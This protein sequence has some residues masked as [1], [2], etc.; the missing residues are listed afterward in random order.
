MSDQIVINDNTAGDSIFVNQQTP[1]QTITVNTGGGVISVN[2]QN[3]IVNLTKFD[4]GLGL[5]DNTSDLDKPISNATLSALLLK[6][7]LSAFNILNNFV[8]SKYGSWDSVYSVVNFNSGGWAGGGGGSSI[9]PVVSGIWQ[10]SASTVSSL[11]TNWNLGYQAVSTTNALALS[12][13][14]WNTAY[15]L[16]SGGIVVSFSL[17]Q[18][19]NW[20]STY[21]TVSSLSAN[22]NSVY[23]TFNTNSGSLTI[24]SSNSA[25]W[26]LAY[27]SI[28]TTNALNL[29]SI[30][31]NTG[32]NL[33][34][35][36]SAINWNYQGT[37]LKGLSANWQTAYQSVSTT[38]TLNLS[39]VYWNTA[40]ASTSA[41][42]LAGYDNEIH[43]SQID[44]ND[45]TGNGDLLNPVASITKALT[46]VGGSRKTVIIHPGG[47][48]E[49]PSITYPYTVLTGPGLVGGNIVIYGT[50]STSTGCTIQ[51]LKMT[52]LTSTT[53]TGAG[54]VNILNCDI[55]NLTQSGTADYTLI[56]FCDITSTNITGS[57]GLI[58]I[59]GGNPN[60]ITINN[61]GAR[62]IAKNVVTVAPVLSAGNATFVD[63]IV[64]AANATSNA[65]TTAPGTIVTLANSQIIVPTFN[66]VARVSL[67]GFYSIFNC[68]YDKPNSTLVALSL[69]GGST[70]SIDYFQYI[71]ADRLILASSGQI[72]FPDGSIQ[73]TAFLNN[74][75]SY[76]T[77]T[78]LQST[79]ALLTPL[80]LTNTLTSQLVTNTTYQNASGNWQSAYTTVNSNSAN[81]N[82]SYVTKTSNFTAAAG[83]Y[84]IVNT[85]TDAVSCTLPLSP[86][87]GDSIYFLDSLYT[88]TTNNFVIIGNGQNIEKQS[89]SVSMNIS[90]ISPT[91]VYAGG[92]SGWRIL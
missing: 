83:S 57:A 18:S 67:S 11:S 33:I 71:N 12:S 7:N 44:G 61:A 47:Y 76:A 4:I 34:Q 69:S 72:T 90:G 52:N 60:S 6:A 22:W 87:I 8:L 53:P 27:Q 48:T 23:T 73:T 16:V 64:I 15:S 91:L 38:N 1:S 62:V 79:S 25:N 39:S 78:L 9:S 28:S 2:G 56:R 50:V 80:T 21:S 59:F 65:I 40:Y 55:G 88:W 41:L 24:L 70:N 26:N 5:V 63:S 92:S 32:Y 29:S 36:N 35:S 45:T 49:N 86:N 10:S 43:V 20:Q 13:I 74:L 31:W 66:N 75:S 51:G 82:G 42:N 54:N 89:D 3:G 37:D 58:A 68:V 85:T 30:Y 46:L 77:N 84:Y 81:W 17:P 19:A 14:Y